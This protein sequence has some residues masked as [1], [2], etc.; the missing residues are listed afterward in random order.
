[1]LSHAWVFKPCYNSETDAEF[2]E[3][4]FNPNRTGVAI[5]YFLSNTLSANTHTD[6]IHALSAI[7]DGT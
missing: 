2:R 5:P 7:P 4:T 3:W 1:M 6:G